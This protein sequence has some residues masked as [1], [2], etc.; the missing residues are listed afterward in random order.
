MGSRRRSHWAYFHNQWP[1][2]TEESAVISFSAGIFTDW[3]FDGV[4]AHILLEHSLLILTL[5]RRGVWMRRC[6]AYLDW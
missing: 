5:Y 2:G 4:M 1:I 6:S 3:T